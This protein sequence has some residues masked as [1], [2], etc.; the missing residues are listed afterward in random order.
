M[1]ARV[2]VGSRRQVESWIKEGRLAINGAPAAL[3]AHIG[4]RDRVTLDGRPVRIREP[5]SDT[6]V[7]LYHRSP[8]SA[9]A[10]GESEQT[11]DLAAKL[12]KRAGR[13]WISVS[14]LPPNDGGLEVLTSDGDL[15]HALM[16]K[17]ATLPVE[18]AIRVR[19]E[20]T[21]GQMEQL[22]AGV[23]PD[24]TLVV[25]SVVPAGG[26]GFNRWLKLIARGARARDVHRLCMAAGLDLSR[27]LRV[28][29]GPLNM[30][31][32]LGREHTQALSAH[33]AEAL[34]A[35]AGLPPPRDTAH[36]KT[37]SAKRAKV[38]AHKKRASAARSGERRRAPAARAARDSPAGARSR[39]GDK[40]KPVRRR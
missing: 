17:I 2:G 30:D 21:L 39:S 29:I 38:P 22:K 35:L 1:L 18:F 36:A 33:E 12:P 16:R 13:R 27:V 15:A 8:R 14:P 25:E 32:A 26:E 7:V 5:D 11:V 19:G 28:S 23:T 4:P 9:P 31:R 40:R 3:G 24:K 6:R 20:P 10:E 37:P 34:Y